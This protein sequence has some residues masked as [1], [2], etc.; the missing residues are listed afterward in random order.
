MDRHAPQKLIDRGEKGY[1]QRSTI[2]LSLTVEILLLLGRIGAA[3]IA[4]RP[5]V[6][7]DD[8]RID[9]PYFLLVARLQRHV[10]K[11]STPW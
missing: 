3:R 2:L 8:R 9:N 6:S 5:V 4:D 1:V 7:I 10:D 11:R